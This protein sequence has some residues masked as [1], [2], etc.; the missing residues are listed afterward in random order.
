M[1]TGIQGL[2]HKDVS[3]CASNQQRWYQIRDL[4]LKGLKRPVYTLGNH[5]G[6]IRK[7]LYDLGRADVSGGEGGRQLGWLA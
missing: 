1:V 2:W 4:A 6:T 7:K 5:P 3:Q